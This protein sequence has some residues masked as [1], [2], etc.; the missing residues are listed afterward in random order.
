MSAAE[1]LIPGS[2]E[3]REDRRHYIGASDTPIIIGL[4]GFSTATEL[5]LE[6]IGEGEPQEDSKEAKRG[7][8]LE[9][10]IGMVFEKVTGLRVEEGFRP[11]HPQHPWLAAQIDFSLP[12]ENS[13]H[14]EAKTHYIY[15]REQDG[16][17]GSGAVSAYDFAQVQHQLAVTGHDE[18][19][20]A[21]LFTDE[22]TFDVLV[23]MLE[24]KVPNGVIAAAVE[25]LD[26]R[27]YHIHRHEERIKEIIELAKDFRFERVL[28]RVPPVDLGKYKPTDNIRKATDAE[29]QAL[30]NYRESWLVSE[31]AIAKEA[32]IKES[33]KLMIGKDSGIN[34]GEDIGVITFKK[35]K[36]SSIETINWQEI[37]GELQQRLEPGDFAAFDELVAKHTTKETTNPSRRFLVPNSKWKKLL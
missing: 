23:T 30:Y 33:I 4:S 27:W 26:F 34:G 10:I 31:R 25:Q 12:D 13:A 15:V 6:K 11:K 37:A 22:D 2:P 9:P 28:K 16:P 14:L 29:T 21:C 3:W 7:R 8:I 17:I 32:R 19:Y 18:A 24:H 36:S 35:P 5:Y 1:K 20:L